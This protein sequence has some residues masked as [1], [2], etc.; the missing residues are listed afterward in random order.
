MLE[1]YRNIRTRREALGMSQAELARRAGYTSRSTIARI[2]RGDIDLSHA[3]IME[4]AKALQTSA[5]ELMGLDGIVPPEPS[6]HKVSTPLYNVAA[7]AGAYNDLYASEYL[8]GEDDSEEYSWCTVH[9]DSMSP[10]LF[11]GDLVK[12]KHQ[13]STTPQDYTVVKVDGEHCTVKHVEI[14]EN[15]VWLR[16]DNKSVYKDRFYTTHEVITLPISIIGKVVEM[17]RNFT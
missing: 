10:T 13:T 14:V 17:R 9:G 16:A 5:A 1:L 12:V 6:E 7:G 11:D 3:K 15:G 2:E 4:I 8:D